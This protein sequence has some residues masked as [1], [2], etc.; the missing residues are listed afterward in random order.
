MN[1]TGCER[2]SSVIRELRMNALSPELVEH[3]RSCADCSETQAVAQVM[4]QVASLRSAAH[5]VPDASVMWRRVESRKREIAVRRAARPLVFMRALSVVCVAFFAVWF[6][7]YFWRASFMELFSGW[8]VL[9]S[10]SA[11]FAALI[12][13]L[14]IVIGAVYLLHDSRR[15]VEGIAST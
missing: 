2:E 10:E 14:A 1:R 5:E 11:F 9:A 15:S 8:S 7:R 4:L 6:L 13:L 12:A 3:V